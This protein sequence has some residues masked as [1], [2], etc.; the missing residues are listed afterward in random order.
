MIE[1]VKCG[2]CGYRTNDGQ[3]CGLN[4]LPVDLEKDNCSFGKVSPPR[5]SIC[6]Q[7]MVSPIF[8]E[9]INGQLRQYCQKCE[10]LIGTCQTCGRAG[11]CSFHEDTS[12]TLP[13]TIQQQ[14]Q[15]PN[16]MTIITQVPNPARIA[17]TCAKQCDCYDAAQG[18]C[19]RQM[20]QGGGC[21]RF[22][23]KD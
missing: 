5:C 19:L 22:V 6:G 21:E 15:Q 10:A 23:L 7:F 3:H 12:V 17:E 13:H 11:Y 9:E 18:G 4:G 1:N 8:V 20:S 16:G 2:R 14:T